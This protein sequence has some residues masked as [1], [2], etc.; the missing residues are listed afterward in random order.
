MNKKVLTTALGISAIALAGCTLNI[1]SSPASMDMHNNSHAA[2]VSHSSF[3]AKAVMFAQMMIPHHRQAIQMSDLAL[4][5]SKNTDVLRLARNI[6][7]AQDPEI[8]EMQRW[9]SDSGAKEFTNDSMM[10]HGMPMQGMLS[11][12]SISALRAATGKEFDVLFLTGM[13]AH[14]QG[15]IAMVNMIDE[16]P[17]Q[18]VKDLGDAI[19]RTQQAEISEMQKLLEK[20]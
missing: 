15:A 11:E 10:D 19:V 8:V 2:E 13:I 6:K 9:L 3:D 16:N 14:H 18:E 7:A 5:I 12:E 20:L 17:N 4:S 1:S